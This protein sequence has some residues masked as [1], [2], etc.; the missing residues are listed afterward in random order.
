MTR[1][2]SDTVCC[3]RSWCRLS[4]MNPE[5]CWHLYILDAFTVVCFTISKELACCTCNC[6]DTK[7]I[8]RFSMRYTYIARALVMVPDRYPFL[9]L[10]YILV[11]S[12]IPAGSFRGC[13]PD[14]QRCSSTLAWEIS[15][16]LWCTQGGL[17]HISDQVIHCGCVLTVLT[18]G[19]IALLLWI[20]LCGCSCKSLIIFSVFPFLEVGVDSTELY[21]LS[22]ILEWLHEFIFLKYSMFGMIIPYLESYL[23]DAGLKWSLG[24]YCL[25][26]G[27]ILMEVHVG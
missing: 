21:L 11:F 14:T 16:I 4:L 5:I 7:A 15:V 2:G 13:R 25:F 23:L 8:Y 6:V 26:W 17:S 1:S 18:L 12:L 20:S 9:P 3:Y 19:N 27:G 10:G 22:F 24:L